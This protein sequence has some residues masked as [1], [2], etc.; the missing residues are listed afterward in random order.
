LIHPDLVCGDVINSRDWANAENLSRYHP[1]C[2]DTFINS[3]PISVIPLM[4]F[5]LEVT[6]LF[7]GA[8]KGHGMVRMQV[9][10]MT[11]LMLMVLYCCIFGK[12]S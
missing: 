4:A 10:D 5:N 9:I 11:S 12:N 8:G 7:A 6:G 3:S 2:R 1:D